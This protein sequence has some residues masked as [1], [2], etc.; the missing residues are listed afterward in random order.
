MYV[1]SY[2]FFHDFKIVLNFIDENQIY[3]MEISQL[4]NA[5]YSPQEVS[6]DR[7]RAVLIQLSCN[8]GRLCV[9]WRTIVPPNRVS[10][11]DCQLLMTLQT[12]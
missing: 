12:T 5:S 10:W 4:K 6:V 11:S 1:Q 2:H 9:S 7:R 8:P 3:N